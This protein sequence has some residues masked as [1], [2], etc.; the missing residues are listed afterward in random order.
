MCGE[1]LRHCTSQYLYGYVGGGGLPKNTTFCYRIL[2]FSYKPLREHLISHFMGFSFGLVRFPV[3]AG[4]LLSPTSTVEL[5]H[6]PVIWISSS[7]ADIKNA[8]AV[9]LPPY[10]YTPS[11][12]FSQWRIFRG[13]SALPGGRGLLYCS[14]PKQNLKYT[15]FI[16]TMI[17]KV[18]RD[19]RF[20]L[21]QP[22]KSAGD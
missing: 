11:W 2:V 12:R 21:N 20:S 14:P 4:F 3:G 15:H 7:N 1:I 19:W 9:C 6:T 22:L 5:T 18:L 16:G 17:S 13:T 10:P 8:S